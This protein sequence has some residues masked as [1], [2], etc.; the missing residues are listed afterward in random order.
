MTN[1]FEVTKD[2]IN[3]T[4]D[5]VELWNLFGGELVR[6]NVSSVIRYLDSLKYP[7]AKIATM[8][9]K[10]YQHVRN[11]LNEPLKKS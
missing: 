10:R 7:R 4:K 5:S 11:V 1:K 2:Q 6:G 8:L 3:G 9:N